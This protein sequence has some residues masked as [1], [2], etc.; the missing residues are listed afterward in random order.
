MNQWTGI[1]FIITMALIN[2]AAIIGMLLFNGI[3]DWMCFILAIAPLL[4]GWWRIKVV[5]TP[6]SR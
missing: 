2:I 5:N 4:I 6:S 3:W 1:P